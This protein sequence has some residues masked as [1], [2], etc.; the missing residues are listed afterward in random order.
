M[1]LGVIAYD[2]TW[3]CKM[4]HVPGAYFLLSF[5]KGTLWFFKQPFK[6]VVSLQYSLINENIF[7]TQ[8]AKLG[9]EDGVREMQAKHLQSHNHHR[10]C[11]LAD[12]YALQAG[13]I[14]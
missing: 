10:H 9:S 11:A 6:A 1:D 13:A 2:F 7:I 8:T 12:G 5:C 3:F 4:P 14:G